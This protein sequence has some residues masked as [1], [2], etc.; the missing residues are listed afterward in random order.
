MS[1]IIM[2]TM[3]YTCISMS[4]FAFHLIDGQTLF[5]SELLSGYDD[6]KTCSNKRHFTHAV[7]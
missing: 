7:L 2:V 5:E 6:V 4:Y 1:D 3:M